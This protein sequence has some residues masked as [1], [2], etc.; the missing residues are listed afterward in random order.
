MFYLAHGKPMASENE[1]GKSCQHLKENNFRNEQFFRILLIIFVS[2]Y[3][4]NQRLNCCRILIY[5]Q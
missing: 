2:Y 3:D 5:D 4:E 1:K